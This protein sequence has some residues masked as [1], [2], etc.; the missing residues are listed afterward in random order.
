[1][2]KRFVPPFPPRPVKPVA[3]WRG[4]FGERAR[5]SV[6]GW[7]QRAFEIDYL[8]RDI[9]GFRV[10]ILLEP[11]LIE[12]V[13]LD[14]AANYG[15]PDI[16]KHLLGPIIGQG[17]LTSDNELWREQRR[18][19]AASF[20]PAAVRAQQ[21]KF[22]EAAQLAMAGWRDGEQRDMAVEAT[23]ATMTIIALALFGGDPRLISETAMAQI[24]AAI[25]GFSEARMLAL[26]RL[27]Q[28]PVTPKGRAGKR[29]QVF[30][31]K[32]LADVVD[33]RWHGRVEPDFLTGV[34]DA[35]RKRFSDQEARALAIDNA[36][37]FYLAG[38]ETTANALTWT[39]FLLAAQP[40]LQEELASEALEA[41]K[42][43]ADDVADRV[44]RLRLFLTESMRLYPPV[45][46][47]DRQA[48]AAD[49]IGE[50]EVEP[51][52]IVSIWPWM[53]HRHRKY[54][55]D[56]DAFD[57]QRFASKEG[58]HRFQYLPF[59]GGPRTCVGAQFATAEALTLLAHWLSAWK[60]VEAGH[61]VRPAGMVTLRPKGGLPLRLIRR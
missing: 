33:D 46:R 50:N 56:P 39:L 47:F 34:I 43:G 48:I 27:P 31:R 4:F 40:A 22:V 14:N 6:Y 45:P 51:G 10:H 55:D 29:G 1:M 38:H 54:W 21:A 44:P 30:L 3:T 7:S 28:I 61:E 17:L 18:I 2:T 52:D 36:A 57:I 35:L 24:A 53:L 41:L 32:I 11:D 16:V 12:H 23:R 9:L 25:E 60:F 59:G 15:K 8:K 37:T 58:R 19:V 49:R 42:G 13:L 20:S 26:L 5:T